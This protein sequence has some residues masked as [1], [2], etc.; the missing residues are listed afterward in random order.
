[1][2]RH[3]GLD[4]QSP[5]HRVFVNAR[6][7][8]VGVR[9]RIY[10]PGYGYRLNLNHIC[11]RLNMD[12]DSVFSINEIADQFR[13]DE[14]VLLVRVAAGLKPE[15]EKVEFLRFRS[16]EITIY[17]FFLFCGLQIK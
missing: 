11:L 3:C 14:Q 5:L 2:V 6:D 9:D 15:L 17:L 1:L 12:S 4:P 8:I 13:N 10:G 16:P 7:C